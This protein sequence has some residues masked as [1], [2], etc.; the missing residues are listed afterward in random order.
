M[1]LLL[2]YYLQLYAFLSLYFFVMNLY[3]PSANKVGKNNLCCCQFA[4]CFINLYWYLLLD[5]A[6][7]T[8]AIQ[9]GVELI[10]LFC[11]H[12]AIWD[13][14]I[15]LG[16]R[17]VNRWTGQRLSLSHRPAAQ[18][19]LVWHLSQDQHK[20]QKRP[21]HINKSSKVCPCNCPQPWPL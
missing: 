12:L 14:H 8:H 15:F 18:R 1:L 10:D 6:L 9:I 5:F 16:L 13:S 2:C 17:V 4:F 11:M 20:Q 19:L 21:A 7:S 3:M